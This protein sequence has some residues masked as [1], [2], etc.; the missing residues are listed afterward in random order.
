MFG[1]STKCAEELWVVSLICHF[2]VR[3]S[4]RKGPVS[5]SALLSTHSSPFAG[6][7]TTLD[8]Y[9]D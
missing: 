1:T 6:F 4:C 8:E 7:D 2:W 5:V 9:L 3:S